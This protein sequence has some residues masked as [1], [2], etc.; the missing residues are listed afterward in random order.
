M[1][2]FQC[3][4]KIVTGDGSAD[5]LG[6]Q[7]QALGITRVVVVTDKVLREK[8][9]S[10]SRAVASLKATGIAVEVFDDVEPDPLVGTARRSAEF[11][12]RFAP[13]GI[14]GL[15]G[16]SPLDIAKATAAILANEA[17]LDQMWGVGNIPKPALPMLLLPTTAGTGSEVTPNCILT[18]VKPDG[19]HMKKGIVSPHILAR[20][21]IVDP[22]L[23]V[24]APPSVT[25]ASGMDALTHAIETYV[26]KSAQPITL[27]LA[28]EAI[29]LIGK[30]LRR[31]VA[32]GSD[33]EARRHMANA[34]M[35]AGLAF[36][37]GFLGGVHAVA[38]AMGGQF[39]VPHGVANALMLPY[40]MEFNEMAATE[41]FARIAETLGESIEG[42]SEREAARRA[43]V[44]VHQLVTDVGLPH[45]LAD[46]RI[47]EDRIPAL[48]EES[49]GNQR[50]LKNNP[51]SA[52]V[53]DL[54]R[55]LE[56]AAGLTR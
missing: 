27:P 45:V 6:A 50:L 46:V 2:E 51:R 15:G 52:T 41:K 31:A 28:L 24:T 42:L 17:P 29:R 39:N 12:R 48:A 26:S 43:A 22:L 4:A 40:V 19:G 10:V 49:F 13:D 21:A 35:L 7:A 23:T 18:D 56:S 44:A 8:T 1:Q 53:Q 55:I 30:Y 25:A 32:N 3:P 16:G 11:A 20:T 54:T 36:A 9:D 14:I 5:A 33:L 47:S 37:N 34:S 38:M